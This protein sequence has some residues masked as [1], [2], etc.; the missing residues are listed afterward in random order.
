MRIVEGVLGGL[1]MEGFESVPHL[2]VILVYP[3]IQ[4]ILN[5]EIKGTFPQS[6]K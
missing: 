3:Q 1:S 5:H 4:C 2:M 6:R